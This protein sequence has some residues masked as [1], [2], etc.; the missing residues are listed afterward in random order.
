M[1]SI[2]ALQRHS[3]RRVAHSLRMSPSS[4]SSSCGRGC[5][6]SNW[7]NFTQPAW[8][9]WAVVVNDYE[10]NSGTAFCQGSC[11]CGNKDTGQNE[12]AAPDVDHT[13]AQVQKDVTA[14]LQW[15]QSNLTF[16]GYRFDMC[17]GYSGQYT[18]QYI[19]AT[20]PTFAVGEYWDDNVNN[21]VNWIKATGSAS[22]AF[23]FPLRDTL[24]G[25]VDSN[26]YSGMM[27]GINPP[28]VIGVMPAN[29][30]TFTDDHDTA[31]NDRF[32][33]TDQI[34]QGYAYLFTHPGTPMIFWDD[35]NTSQIQ[36]ALQR[37]MQIRNQMNL[38]P[39]MSLYID[40]HQS[41]LYAAYTGTYLALPRHATPRL[42][43]SRTS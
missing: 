34:I 1:A 31:R 28:G 5:Q 7:V 20:K 43:S 17:V 41:G 38:T 27:S 22:S 36:S 42:V 13:N 40:K 30:V 10:C 8:Q 12:C 37:L 2:G 26:N 15:L 32:G 18:G 25:C 11:Q 24:K 35:W 16:T 4:S 3:W 21:V 23:D 39:T 33:S 19:R 6:P 9:S 14:W 29:S